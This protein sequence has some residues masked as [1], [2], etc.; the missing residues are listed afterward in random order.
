MHARTAG[1][2]AGGDKGKTETITL[3]VGKQV[4]AHVTQPIHSYVEPRGT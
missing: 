4:V 2:Q 1:I 3:L